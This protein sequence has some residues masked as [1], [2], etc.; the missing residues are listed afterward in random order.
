MTEIS[1]FHVHPDYSIDAAGTIRQYCDRA[2]EIG[3]RNICFTSHYD[4][5]PR[6]VEADGYWRHKGRRVR[7]D[8]ELVGRYIDEIDRAQRYYAQ[9]GLRVFRGLEIDYFPGVEGE[10]QRVRDKYGLD[11]VIGSVHCLDDIAI[12]DKREAP[13][14][15][16][17]KTLSRMVDDY[18]GLLRQAAETPAFDCLGHLD[19]Y[20]RYGHLYYGDDI[21][22]IELDHFDGIFDTLKKNGGGLEVNT[23][24]FRFGIRKFHP[25]QEIIERAVAAGVSIISVGSDAHRPQTLGAGVIEAYDLLTALGVRPIFPRG[26]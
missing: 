23:S 12:S 13:G 15:F 10:A 8:D 16:L 3:L 21:Y 22:K 17:K 24:L 19:Y 18:F 26:Q 9:F 4:S 20:V 6:R 25:A 5:N 14:Y 2:L 1:D 7:F 11:F